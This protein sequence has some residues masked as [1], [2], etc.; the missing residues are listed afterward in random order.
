MS[1]ATAAAAVV[2]LRTTRPWPGEALLPGG[3]GGRWNGGNSASLASI[4]VPA[5]RKKRI[6]SVHGAG[7]GPRTKIRASEAIADAAADTMER[8]AHSWV[9]PTRPGSSRERGEPVFRLLSKYGTPAIAA[10]AAGMAVKGRLMVVRSLAN[11]QLP[12]T[13]AGSKA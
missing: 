2:R 12:A 6:A 7:N 3:A 9:R 11:H 4:T 5:I 8:T 10:Q 1:P 13:K